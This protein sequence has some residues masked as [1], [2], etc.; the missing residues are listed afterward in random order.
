MTYCITKGS[1]YLTSLLQ[2]DFIRI[3]FPLGYQ[4]FGISD[5]LS[6]VLAA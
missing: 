6:E 2:L 5:E 3:S 4:Q 1:P